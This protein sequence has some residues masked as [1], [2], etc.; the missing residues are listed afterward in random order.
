M[1]GCMHT[2]AIPVYYVIF[3]ASFKTTKMG[4]C[5]KADQGSFAGLWAIWICLR[6]VALAGDVTFTFMNSPL[7]KSP[8]D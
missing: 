1:E 6:Q 3:L 5:L 2:R 4:T 8:Q 7:T